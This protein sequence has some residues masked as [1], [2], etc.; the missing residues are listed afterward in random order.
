[1]MKRTKKAAALL[2]AAAMLLALAACGGDTPGAQETET[3]D[4]VYV[5]SYSP[6]GG[7]IQYVN[8]SCYFNGRIYFVGDYLDGQRTESYPVYDENGEPLLDE[9]GER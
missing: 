3:P 5:A 1:M 7:D 6:V 9:N 2:L 8:Q 4:F